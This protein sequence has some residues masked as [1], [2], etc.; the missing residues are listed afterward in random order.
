M[1]YKNIACAFCFK[2]KD[3][4]PFGYGSQRV[5][6]TRQEWSVATFFKRAYLFGKIKCWS[7]SL[8]YLMC[9][10][11]GRRMIFGNSFLLEKPFYRSPHEQNWSRVSSSWSS[12]IKHGLVGCWQEAGVI[13]AFSFSRFDQTISVRD[14]LKLLLL[15]PAYISS[16]CI[17]V[18]KLISVMTVLLLIFQVNTIIRSKCLTK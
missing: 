10:K 7:L 16:Q 18:F 4:N 8:Y 13:E 9:G 5:P 12:F 1:S 11:N 6:N 17:S 15:Q 2:K 3:L 14:L